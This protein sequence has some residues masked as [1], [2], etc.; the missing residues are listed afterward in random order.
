MIQKK[1]EEIEET[2]N[3]ALLNL[4]N[5]KCIEILEGADLVIDEMLRSF[6]VNRDNS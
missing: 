2:I 4:P 1:I 6:G 5:K 3:D